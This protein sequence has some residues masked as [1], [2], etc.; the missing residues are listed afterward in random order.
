MWPFIEIRIK[1]FD[2]ETGI[3]LKAL[4]LSKG[5]DSCYVTIPLIDYAEEL[6]GG[7]ALKYGIDYCKA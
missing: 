7:K 4:G 5:C 6:Y 3:S 2:A 1:E